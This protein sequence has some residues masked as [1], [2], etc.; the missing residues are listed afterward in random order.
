MQHSSKTLQNDV[1]FMP[2]KTQHR[3]ALHVQISPNYAGSKC[4]C[5]TS[6]L[7]HHSSNSL[8]GGNRTPVRATAYLT[9]MPRP[10]QIYMRSSRSSKY[11]LA[12]LGTVN[13]G[14]NAYKRRTAA[15]MVIAIESSAA[16][17]IKH[18]QRSR[19]SR[20]FRRTHS[21]LDCSN[22]R[23]DITRTCTR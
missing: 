3:L 14:S 13:Y 7:L 21:G 17:P 9:R 22:S 4:L 15:L 2:V 18:G 23:I 10:Q 19:A 20:V 11:T 1:K 16:Q 8:K 6:R 5:V 12:M